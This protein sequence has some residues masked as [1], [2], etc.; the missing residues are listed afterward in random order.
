MADG[1]NARMQVFDS[2]GAFLFAFAE[3]GV[4]HEGDVHEDL[5]NAAQN[6]S[7]GEK[8]TPLL[9]CFP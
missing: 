6:N 8:S 7:R 1:D 4:G 2:T 3:G 9:P 5:M